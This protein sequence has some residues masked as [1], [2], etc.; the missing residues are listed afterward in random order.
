MALT[1]LDELAFRTT[2]DAIYTRVLARLDQEDPD[3]IE[4]EMNAGVVRIRN[5]RGQVYVLNVQPPLREIWYA[6]GDRAWHFQLH[7]GVWLD[8]RN[9]DALGQVLDTTVSAASGLTIAFG[10]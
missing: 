9:Q 5:A 4:G 8:P 1:P 6:A 3:V 2:V 10:L 7:D